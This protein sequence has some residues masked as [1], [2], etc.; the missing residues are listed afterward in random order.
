MS[1]DDY[2]LAFR[3]EY[4]NDWMAADGGGWMNFIYRY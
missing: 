1:D 3:T 2:C 4:A